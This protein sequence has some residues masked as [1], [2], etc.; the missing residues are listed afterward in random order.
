MRKLY[1]NMQSRSVRPL[2]KYDPFDEKINFKP[3][4]FEF[5]G[6]VQELEK[7]HNMQTEYLKK[8]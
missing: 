6:T 2:P 4:D 3:G 8:F 5:N 1:S 7:T